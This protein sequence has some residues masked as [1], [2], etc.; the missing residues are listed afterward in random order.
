L[1]VRSYITGDGRYHFSGVSADMDY[2]LRAR[3]RQYWSKPHP[4]S[5]FDS[6]KRRDIG[7]VIPID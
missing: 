5:R 2:K 4:L 3:Y 1:F 7:L 6:P